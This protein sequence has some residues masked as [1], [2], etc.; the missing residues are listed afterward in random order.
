MHS[1]ARVFI[2]SD[3]DSCAPLLCEQLRENGFESLVR[4]IERSTSELKST[5]RPDIVVLDMSSSKARHY[6]EAYLTLAHAV[7]ENSLCNHMRILLIGAELNSRLDDPEQTID[8]LIL[9]PVNIDLVCHRIQ[10]LVRLNRM[11]DE[12]LRRLNTSAKYGTE[13][14]TPKLPTKRLSNTRILYLGDPTCFGNIESTISSDVTLIGALTFGTALDYLKRERFDTIMLSAGKEPDQYLSFTEDLRRN[15][16]H[17]NLPI[18]LLI[19]TGYPGITERA[20]RAG[21]TEILEQPVSP[22]ELRLRV[23]YLVRESRFRN[24]LKQIYSQARHFATND[25]LTGLYSRGFLLEHLSSMTIEAEKNAQTFALVALKIDNMHDINTNIGYASGDRIIRQI[26]EVIGLLVRG[27]DIA[28][29]Y[30]GHEFMILLPDSPPELAINAVNRI[31]SVIQS[32]KLTIENLN[33]PIEVKLATSIIGYQPGTLPDQ[34]V[35]RAWQRLSESPDH[36]P[37]GKNNSHLLN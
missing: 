24:S 26:G 25:S 4:N 6:P 16:D 31:R 35:K 32:T 8:D 30:G 12:L 27:E 23:L 18:L 19:P 1:S 2:V 33:D 15:S 21:V 34:L 29:R 5:S 37:I 11:Q 22:E 17:Y 14:T 9:G 3:D 13:A 10:S 36:M 28:I 20:F 7:K